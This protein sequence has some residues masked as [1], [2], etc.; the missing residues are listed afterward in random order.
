V[1]E[2]SGADR[3]YIREA[4]DLLE[5]Q[6]TTLRKWESLGVLPQHLRP[7]RGQRGWRYWTPDQIDGIKKWMRD[8]DRRPGKGLPHY[9]PTEEQLSEVLRKMRRPR[10]MAKED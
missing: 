4:S 2:K 6:M 3:I 8:T 5:R 1:T 9:H 10:R 7:H